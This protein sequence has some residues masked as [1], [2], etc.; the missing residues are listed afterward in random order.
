M[1]RIRFFHSNRRIYSMLKWLQKEKSLLHHGNM[2]LPP[3]ARR[4]LNRF[5]QSKGVTDFTGEGWKLKLTTKMGREGTWSINGDDDDD[6]DDDDDHEDDMIT[7]SHYHDSWSW[8]FDHLMF[9]LFDH[10]DNHSVMCLISRFVVCLCPVSLS[11]CVCLCALLIQMWK[12][13]FSK[14]STRRWWEHHRWVWSN[15]IS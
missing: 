15:I 10:H 9:W 4:W 2:V 14:R 12:Q 13:I 11:V 3:H 6:D 1:V 5:P 8:S 7:R